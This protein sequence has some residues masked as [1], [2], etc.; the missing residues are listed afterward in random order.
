MIPRYCR[1]AMAELWSDRN[2][3]A[4][5]LRV[6][7][8]ALEAMAAQ[9]MIPAQAVA[10]IKTRAHIDPQAIAEAEKR[11][12]HEFNAFIT[13]IVDQVGIAGRFFHFGLTASDILDTAFALQ[14]TAAA[15]ILDAGLR[16]LTQALM[17]RA[18]EHA[19]SLCIGRTHGM[20]AE[21]TSFGLKLLGLAAACARSRQRLI[22]ARKEIAH[23]TLS[24]P[25]GTYAQ[26]RPEIETAV[27]LALG[28]RA[29]AVASQI[30]PRDRHAAFFCAL[31]QAAGVLELLALE[32]RHLQRS[33]VAEVAEPFAAAQTG[34]SAMPHKRN[35]ILSENLSGLARLIRAAVVPALESVALWHERDMSHSSVERVLAPQTTS[36]LDFA[37]HRAVSIVQGLE[38][39]SLAM[40]KRV[41]ESGGIWA[42]HALVLALI[43]KGWAR[44]AAYQLLKDLSAK[45][46]RTRQ[47]LR[48]LV[49]NCAQIT[50]E[51]DTAACADCFAAEH[52]LREV[53][54]I[55]ARTQERWPELTP[56]AR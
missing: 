12:H 44:G 53:E 34:S 48:I 14:L 21:P 24:G 45:A 7:L 38:I 5:W 20:Y 17:R 33:E 50:R 46:A 52:H 10:E 28:L 39:D 4:H 2:R 13:S 3:F 26:L 31:G 35:P 30:I 25:V 18:Q 8:C 6:E 56:P 29:E 19:H 42:S 15:D 36:L 9:G 32:I 41:E 1:P 22:V 37:L 11:L 23:L 49:E 43:T 51:L 54:T 16:A 27:G 47:P 40:R 55:F